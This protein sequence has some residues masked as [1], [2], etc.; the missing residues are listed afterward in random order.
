MKKICIVFIFFFVFVSFMS[1]HAQWAVTFGW[2]GME[3]ALCVQQTSDGGYILGGYTSSYGAGSYDFWIV[4]LDADFQYEWE[5]VYGGTLSDVATSIQETSDGGYIVAGETVSFGPANGNMWIMKLDSTGNRVWQR[6]YGGVNNDVATSIQETSDGGF[7]VGGHTNSFGAGDYDVWVLK[8]FSDGTEDWHHTS[9]GTGRE[10]CRSVR[11]TSDGG[12]IMAGSTS[13]SGAGGDDAWV[14]KFTPSGTIDWQMTYGGVNADE[15]WDIQETSEGVYVLVGDTMSFGAGGYD[16][17]ALKLDS[18]GVLIWQWTFGGV[19]DDRARSVVETSDD[20]YVVAGFTNSYGAGVDDTWIIKLDIT[21]ALLWQITH[22]GS[23]GEVI[24]CIQETSEGGFIASGYTGSHGAG[25][26]DVLLLKLY[27]DGGIYAPCGMTETSMAVPAFTFVSGAT[28]SVVP[29]SVVGHQTNPTGYS[30]TATLVG[31]DIW[32]EAPKVDLTTAAN[33]SN[34]GTTNPPPGT[35]SYYI[36]SEVTVTAAAYSGYRFSSWSGDAS[37]TTSSIDITMDANKS[38]TANFTVLSTD[39]GDGDGNGGGCFIATAAYGSPSHFYV[40]ILR[41]FRDEYLMSGKP[42]RS[43]VKFYYKHSP[44]AASYLEKHSVLKIPIRYHLHSIVA[45]SYMILHFGPV[46][47]AVA[48]ILII[49]IPVLYMRS[50][51]RC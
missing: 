27:P 24:E 2:T 1:L 28:S 32:C 38:V 10:Y 5:V 29:Q 35:R 51:R 21:G 43:F 31:A 49:M 45:L 16:I 48:F 12:Y 34:G 18:A 9:G 41:D 8:L 17:W 50:Y 22:G 3:N 23:S 25:G 47:T 39:D 7:I 19:G 46:N 14:V 20:G 33:P 42:G 26:A 13:S 37:G 4:K 15:G 11:Q 6:Y 44:K 30:P 40:N 36:N